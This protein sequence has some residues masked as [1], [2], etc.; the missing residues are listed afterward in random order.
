MTNLISLYAI[1]VY[2]LALGLIFLKIPFK[3]RIY[4]RLAI[5]VLILIVANIS[6]EGVSIA[7]FMYSIFD[8][9]S[10]FLLV[11]C[12]L[13]LVRTFIKTT[14]LSISYRGF[15]SVFVVWIL[16][17]LNTLGF[18]NIGFGVYNDQILVTAF[19]IAILYLIDTN[20]GIL[21]LISFFLTLILPFH[22]E[23]LNGFIGS[24]VALFGFLVQGKKTNYESLHKALLR[25]NVT[26]S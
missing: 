17:F 2:S 6:I 24:F 4:T 26:K 13:S 23:I 14:P 19:I 3:L 10:I 1:F 18:F 9:P 11:V 20:L 22:I 5:F 25:P 8:M 12:I 16:L 15:I 7:K 21:L